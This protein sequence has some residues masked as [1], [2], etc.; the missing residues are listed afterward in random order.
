MAGIRIAVDLSGEKEL[1]AALSA[2][3]GP[4]QGKALRMATRDAL[5]AVLAAVR[6]DAPKKTGKLA[7]GIK[8][9]TMKA[10][11]W[12][13][14]ARIV[15]PTRR[16]LGIPDDA[17]G[18]YPTAQEYGFHHL[19]GKNKTGKGKFIP[20]QPFLRG[21]FEARQYIMVQTFRVSIWNALKKIAAEVPRGK[22]K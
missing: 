12:V 16:R 10:K 17:A 14:G 13:G 22:R 19:G 15:L 3:T 7:R 20:A 9:Y 6:R 21:N 4:K 2:L 1:D 18:Y 5:K 11:K 8:I